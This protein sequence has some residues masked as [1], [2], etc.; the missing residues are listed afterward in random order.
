MTLACAVLAR[1]AILPGYSE[2]WIT[3]QLLNAAAVLLAAYSY[4]RG[5][6]ALETPP[7]HAM[8][9]VI[10]TAAILALLNAVLAPFASQDLY[11]Y[12]SQG[13]EQYHYHLNPYLRP[14]SSIPGAQRDPMLTLWFNDLCVYGFLF[15]RLERALAWLGGGDPHLTM[16]L[17]K[18][19][20]LAAYAATAWLIAA[21]GRRLGLV[22]IDLALYLFLWNPMILIQHLANGHNDLLM[23][24]FVV[25]AIYL[26]AAE[27]WLLVLPALAAGLLVKWIAG[28]ILPF[29][30]VLVA[31][32]RGTGTAVAGALIAAV[33]VAWSGAPYLHQWSRAEVFWFAD[34][35]LGQMYSLGSAVLWSLMAVQKVIPLGLSFERADLIVA[36]LFL[37]TAAVLLL[38]QFARFAADPAPSTPNFVEVSVF[39]E[40][41]LI[42]V[43]LGLF[44]PHHVG[45][46]F[47]AALVL[48]RGH[49]LRRLAI[50]L[51]I[52]PLEYFTW[53]DTFRILNS[54]LMLGLPMLWIGYT[55]WPEVRGA[56][57]GRWS[58]RARPP[59]DAQPARASA[60][61]AQ[62]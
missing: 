38:I 22:R 51:T 9:I 32:R 28:V 43:G 47:A 1:T 34:P 36:P 7:R 40:M 60:P 50:A 48:E 41:A 13:W 49:W 35:L 21:A 18:A 44:W 33:L 16:L 42:C 24:L 3:G 52:F 8:R 58:F 62:G 15:V 17:F 31:R 54:M 29:A 57:A 53:L 20:D 6:R 25:L 46:F 37:A 26:A 2:R 10:G 11:A 56:L 39:S 45:M 59:L 30:F 12:I 23:A 4:W 27:L 5:Y 61:G 14:V 55:Q 19:T